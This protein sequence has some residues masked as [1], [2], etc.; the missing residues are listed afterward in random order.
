MRKIMRIEN[1]ICIN[2]LTC[3]PQLYKKNY[4]F[5]RNFFF[6][7]ILIIKKPL[8]V[9]VEKRKRKKETNVKHKWKEMGVDG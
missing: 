4:I 7:L 2:L 6:M 5:E 3:M 9:K 8:N 1:V